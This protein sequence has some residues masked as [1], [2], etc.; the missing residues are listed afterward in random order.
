M[1]VIRKLSFL[2]VLS[3]ILPLLI[4]ACQEMAP[5]SG[6]GTLL[7]MLVRNPNI[8]FSNV[9][10]A[11]VSLRVETVPV[12]ME[13]VALSVT[14]EDSTTELSIEVNG[15]VEHLVFN[16]QM[17]NYPAMSSGVFDGV[18]IITL[19]CESKDGGSVDGVVVSVL[20]EDLG[21]DVSTNPDYTIRRE[22]IG[23]WK[24]DVFITTENPISR[25]EFE[26]IADE[27]DIISA[28]ARSG[29]F[30][31]SSV[32]R[33]GNKIQV[34]SFV[35]EIPGLEVTSLSPVYIE[36]I[37]EKYNEFSPVLK[38]GV[39]HASRG[40]SSWAISVLNPS[41]DKHLPTTWGGIKATR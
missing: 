16:H 38:S 23:L 20:I 6:T 32:I 28:R 7:E 33:A 9:S 2:L 14:T 35:A 19:T 39:I 11:G 36:K 25:V 1:K 27:D 37:R 17:F 30:T 24:A 34:K 26:L 12:S 3:F 18:G 10:P 22:E 21:V 40:N 8:G 13:S 41:V 29:F 5:I 31:N 15:H 4:G